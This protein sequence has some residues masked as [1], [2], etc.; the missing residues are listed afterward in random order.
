MLTFFNHWRVKD[1]VVQQ[2][3]NSM[4][5][6]YLRNKLHLNS[7]III[8]WCKNRRAAYLQ[9][10]ENM[11]QVAQTLTTSATIYIVGEQKYDTECKRVTEIVYKKN[12]IQV[13]SATSYVL[14]ELKYTNDIYSLLQTMWRMI[15]HNS[16]QD[17]TK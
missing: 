5:I 4:N 10:T 1:E 13:T 12:Q 2:L 6:N 15:G 17:Q 14:N 7:I 11:L 16:K 3:Q 9:T 8:N